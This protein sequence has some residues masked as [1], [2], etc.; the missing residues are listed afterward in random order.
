MKIDDKHAFLCAVRDLMVRH[1]VDCISGQSDG[2]IY[3]GSNRSVV[4]FDLGT[5]EEIEQEIKNL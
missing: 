4:L 3:V 5:I 2:S 1:G